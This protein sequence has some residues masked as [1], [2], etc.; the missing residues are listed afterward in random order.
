MRLVDANVLIYAVNSDA[1]HHERSRDW[2]GGALSGATT[3]G[4]SWIVLTAFLR[5]STK[6]SL[7]PSP[8]TASQALDV[9]DSW[10]SAPSAVTVEPTAK[11]LVLLRGLL[12]RSGAGNLV[13]DAH[14]AALAIEHRA[15]IVTFDTDFARFPDVR[16]E[17]PPV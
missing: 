13:N 6:H 16:W 8:L 10:L 7:F 3:V 14:I 5:L 2:L 4:F 11:H 9:I 17:L 15:T 1:E 12:E